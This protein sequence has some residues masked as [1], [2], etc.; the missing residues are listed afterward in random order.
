MEGVLASIMKSILVVDDDDSFRTGLSK[1]LS[2]EGYETTACV[3]GAAALEAFRKR[4]VDLVITD[5][6]MPE[7]EG[8]ETILELRRIAPKLKI[9]AVSGGGRNGP[10]DYLPIAEHFGAARTLAKPFDKEQILQ[11]V[12]EVLGE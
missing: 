4:A 12:R 1:V 8:L 2:Q 5:I 11:A 6:I 7:K 9:I 10:E 3:D